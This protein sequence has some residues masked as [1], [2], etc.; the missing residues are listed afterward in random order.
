[1]AQTFLDTILAHIQLASPAPQESASPAPKE[2]VSSPSNTRIRL[3]KPWEEDLTSCE[4]ILGPV[5]MSKG[6]CGGSDQTYESPERLPV[7][8]RPTNRNN[9]VE[10]VTSNMDDISDGSNSFSRDNNDDDE[11]HDEDF[12]SDLEYFD[13]NEFLKRMNAG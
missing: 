13:V 3:R 6:L 7:R 11:I 8:S 12:Y 9:T 5:S 2:Q 4:L 10:R 1:M